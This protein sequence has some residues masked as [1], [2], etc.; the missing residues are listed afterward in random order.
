M[1]LVMRC[2][3]ALLLAAFIAGSLAVSPAVG[4][5]PAA[6]QKRV[7]L[8]KIVLAIPL[9]ET[10]MEK[11]PGW[12]CAAVRPNASNGSRPT[13]TGPAF[14][15]F[16]AM[17]RDAA[18]EQNI[19]Y[20]SASDDLFNQSSS[21][22]DYDVAGVITTNH[23]KVCVQ[24]NGLQRATVDMTVEW[25]LF[26]VLGTQNPMTSTSASVSQDPAV[27]GGASLA[28][29]KAFKANAEKLWQS[30]EVRR[31]L[32]GAAVAEDGVI[33]PPKDLTPLKITLAD[34]S[35]STPINDTPA[36]TVQ[37]RSGLGTGS[38]V[39]ISRD[40]YVVTAAHVVGDAPRVK[41]RWSDGAEFDGEVVR[42]NAG[43][44]VALIRTESRGRTPLPLLIS[45]PDT[46]AVVYAVGAP[47][48][49]A[50]Q[51][52]VTR[53]VLS[54]KPHMGGYLFLQSDVSVNPGNSG[55]PLV[56]ERGRVVGVTSRGIRGP[57]VSGLNFFIPAADVISFL[58]LTPN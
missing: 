4:A 47:L 41:V 27:A 17:V 38:G 55:G 51:G 29:S 30:P 5:E 20:V 9:G 35:G 15:S 53:G 31:N 56:D 22:P 39:L 28:L 1:G 21:N 33:A 45:P 36:S 13:M 44:D 43:R 52:T 26:S 24:S 2:G 11:L 16:E 7:K 10:V 23:E 3:F 25:Q 46:G 19:A 42:I 34:T 14:L 48:D 57:V 40:G 8:V 32:F 12:D 50:L 49:K 37:I 6:A 18:I 54:G 58:G